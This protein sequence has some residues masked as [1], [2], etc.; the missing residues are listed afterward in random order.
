MGIQR[1]KTFCVMIYSRLLK[2]I[3]VFLANALYAAFGR[4]YYFH[5]ERCLRSDMLPFDMTPPDSGKIAFKA[6]RIVSM[7]GEKPARG[8]DLFAPLAS[9]GNC[10]LVI[11][12]GRIAAIG[13]SPPACRRVDLGDAAILP[14]LVN[15]HTHLQLSWLNGKTRFGAGFTAWLASMLQTLLPA[16]SPGFGARAQLDALNRACETLAANTLYIG[17]VG[18]SI[19][20]S[21]AAVRAAA[22]KH[23]I[24]ALHFCEWF[25]FGAC[26]GIWP[27]RCQDEIISGL[28]TDCAPAGHALYSTSAQILKQAHK[29]CLEHKRVFSFHLAESEDETELLT[30]GAGPLA[31]LYRG[32]VLPDCWQPPGIRPL[33]YAQKLGLL[34]PGTLAVHGAQL[35]KKET[36][37]FAASGSAL[38]LCPRS[39]YNLAVGQP[40]IKEL[41][42][43]GTLCC[44]G[45]D[46]LA[47]NTDLNI[48]NE[49]IFLR[50]NLDLPWQALQRM[51]TVNGAGALGM[52]FSGLKPGEPAR[53]SI[54]P[55]EDNV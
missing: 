47:S 42:E 10:W 34:G 40:P 41:I 23:G 6:K 1:E 4:I 5:V 53:F 21:L 27:E 9:R 48:L 22:R 14:P 50:Q 54:W 37:A 44:L 3:F 29:F 16:I 26:A 30:A 11:E 55:E 36:A 25:G 8:G 20:G 15:A 2:I 45:T 12:K 51:A 39:N 32:K 13:Q 18:G 28:E 38:C 31:E 49:A 17:D 19:K 43:A 35:D 33:A 24:A 7:S 52:R 46:S